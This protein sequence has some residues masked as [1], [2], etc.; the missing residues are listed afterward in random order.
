M[1]IPSDQIEQALREYA[2]VVPSL[3]AST[4]GLSPD[5]LTARPGPG[6][7]SIHEVVLH[8]VD[9]DIVAWDRMKRIAAMERPTLIPYDETAFA[10][11]LFY[12]EQ[13]LEDALALF[14]LGRRQ[15]SRILERLPVEAFER[16]GLHTDDGELSLLDF[17]RRYVGHVEHHVRFIDAK[18]ERL[19]VP[20]TS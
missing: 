6:D 16:K 4:V 12:H 8:T 7:W 19:G 17:V 15:M 13:S 11:T 20:R 2:R 10:K 5:Q 9:S 14:E 1:S 18:R 3:R